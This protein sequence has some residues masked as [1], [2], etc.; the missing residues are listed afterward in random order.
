M[1]RSWNEPVNSTCPIER[2]S[3]KLKRLNRALQSW[4]SK[5]VGHVKTQLALAREVLHRLE[6]AQDIRS[7]TAE[8][9]KER[10]E[11]ALS[12]T[13]LTGK[14]YCTLVRYLKDGDANT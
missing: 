1:E 6:I 12:C 14:N 5:Q 9:A 2:I 10:T 11:T 8:L 7:L 13:C 3:I 4:S